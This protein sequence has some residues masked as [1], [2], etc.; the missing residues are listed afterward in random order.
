MKERY[1]RLEGFS[2]DI[3]KMRDSHIVVVGVGGLGVVVLDNLARL[4]AGTLEYFDFDTLEWANL[5]R[6]VFLPSQIGKKKVDAITEYLSK[7]NSDVELLPRVGDVTDGEGL[8][9]FRDS[10]E[11]ADAVLG[12][13]DSPH[14]RNFI[15]REIVNEGVPYFDGGA[16]E[17]GINGTVQTIL[18]GKF[19]CYRCSKPFFSEKKT[20][21]RVGP[22]GMCFATSLPTTMGIIGCLETQ[23]VLKFITGAGTPSPL[24]IYRGLEGTVESLDMKKDPN[25]PICG[26][27]D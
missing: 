16:R 13:V 9:R 26:D 8:K 17:D 7:V 21:E 6:S 23:E 24:L 14:V 22:S 19:P 20:S 11:R 2:G 4:G 25:C 27:A 10:M 15:N 12:C 18:P 1:A 3:E 5:N